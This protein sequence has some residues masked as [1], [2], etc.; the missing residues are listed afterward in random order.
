[1]ETTALMND[2]NTLMCWLKIIHPPYELFNAK[3]QRLIP[4][5]YKVPGDFTQRAPRQHESTLLPLS[6]LCLYKGIQVLT[7]KEHWGSINQLCKGW[8]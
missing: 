7:M 8:D 6:L 2:S 5:N 4:V 1:M 3:S